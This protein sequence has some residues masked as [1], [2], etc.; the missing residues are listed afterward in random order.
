M[1][2]CAD[3]K[4]GI[5]AIGR[6]EGERLRIC[7]QSLTRRPGAVIVYVDSGSTDNSVSLAR[8]FQAHVVE[9][10]MSRPFTAARARNEGFAQ[11]LKLAQDIAFVQ[12]LDGDCELQP[13]WI[14]QAIQTFQEHPRAGV[15][16]GRRRERFPQKSLYN[17]LCDIEW[18]TPV[19]RVM[20]CGGDAMIRVQAFQEVGGYNPNVIAGEEPEMCVRLRAKGWEIYRI[21]AEM[22]L[23]DADMTRFSQWW[24]RNY[25]AGHAY[26]QGND[27]HGNPP[28]RFREKEVRSN[29]IWGLLW[30]IPLAWPLHA[31]LMLKIMHDMKSRRGLPTSDAFLYGLFVTLGK[32]PQFLG[33]RKYHR[34]R[35][36]GKQSTLIEYKTASTS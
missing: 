23:H 18:N 30:F 6:N 27:L 14:D 36:S 34:N 7:L 2:T 29:T 22:T 9:L 20:S 33:Q 13:D 1:N 17:R 21:D 16:C 35:M 10:D 3:M 24:K 8:S 19:G 31:I 32:L 11:L 12:F 15:V 28:E 4:L 25:R 26:A 5:V